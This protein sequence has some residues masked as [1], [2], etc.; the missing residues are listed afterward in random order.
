MSKHAL[1]SPSGADRWMTCPGSVLLTKDLPEETSEYAQEGTNY[2]LL[3]QLCLEQEKDAFEFVGMPFEDETVV[4]EDNAEHVQLYVDHIRQ[5]AAK[6][7]TVVIEDKLPLAQITGEKDAEGTSD[8]TIIRDDVVVVRDLKFGRGVAVKAENNRQLKMYALG[9]IE[10]HGMWDLVKEVDL[11]ICQ[12]RLTSDISQVTMPIDELKMFKQ[13]VQIVS[14]PILKALQTGEQ[15]PLNPSEKACRFCKAAKAGICEALTLTVR[16]AAEEGFENLDEPKIIQTPKGP[17]TV[18]E[19]DRLGEAMKL[20]DLAEIYVKGVR[21]ATESALLAS[22]PVTGYKLVQGRK[23]ARQWTDEKVIEETLKKKRVKHEEM[24]TYKLITPTKAEKKWAK[25][26]PTWWK[27]L[28]EEGRISQSSG[29]VSIA[30]TEDPRPAYK[31]EPQ[32]S[33]F[34]ESVEDL[35]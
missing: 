25:E 7:G 23:G 19:A 13:E 24:Y 3:A 29:S 32:E 21:S 17:V 31:V 5:E 15:L 14:R 11:G 9:A 6:G 33:G 34:E 35:F 8:C 1:L 2:H 10:K 4:D 22:R 16:N 27:E 12:P 18:S 20:A 26:K 28:S 30:P